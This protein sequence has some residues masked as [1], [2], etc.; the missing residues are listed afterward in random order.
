[1][2]RS[3]FKNIG[4]LED[5]GHVHLD[6]IHRP[7]GGQS[8]SGYQATGVTRGLPVDRFDR[9]GGL[10]GLKFREKFNGDG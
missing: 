2:F 9:G 10:K 4:D 5:N 8:Q 7:N 6:Q 1:M 3:T